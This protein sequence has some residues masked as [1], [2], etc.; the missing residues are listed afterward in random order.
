VVRSRRDQF[1]DEG[2]GLLGSGG[3]RHHDVAE[4]WFPLAGERSF[5]DECVWASMSPG[6]RVF[7]VRRSAHRSRCAPGRPWTRD[8]PRRSWS[9]RS[10]PSGS[11]G[12]FHRRRRERSR[13]SWKPRQSCSA[14]RSRVSAALTEPPQ[15][16]TGGSGAARNPQSVCPDGPP[17]NCPVVAAVGC[18]WV[19][20]PQVRGGCGRR[21]RS[22]GDR[23]RSLRAIRCVA[24]S[25][26]APGSSTRR[27]PHEPVLL[28]NEDRE[29][30]APLTLQP[31]T[32]A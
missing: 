31:T 19:P 10:S 21:T 23:A 20:R 12:R 13:S 9:P 8:G 27:T 2:H 3:E 1:R 29:Q 5:R 30:T 14:G 17:R 25:T 7:P 15:R 4:P 11:R 28:S 32:A 6:S 22:R 16:A 26:G 24:V 18:A